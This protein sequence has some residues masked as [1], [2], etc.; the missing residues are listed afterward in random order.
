MQVK[1]LRRLIV[2]FASVMMLVLAFAPLSFAGEDGCDSDNGCGHATGGGGSDT[3]S[4]KGGAQTGFGGVLA[5]NDGNVS[6]PF[7]LAS[8]GAVL[9][10]LAGGLALRGRRFEQ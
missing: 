8:G 5:A 1:S 3:G 9:L 4:A 10:T 7:T 2:T 6:I